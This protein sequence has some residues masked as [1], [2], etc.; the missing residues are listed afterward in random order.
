MKLN[1]IDK[2]KENVERAQEIRMALE[3]IDKVLNIALTWNTCNLKITDFNAYISADK[4]DFNILTILLN[5]EKQK[6]KEE[7]EAL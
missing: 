1:E 3:R 6:L 2:I 7:L 5:K 4:A